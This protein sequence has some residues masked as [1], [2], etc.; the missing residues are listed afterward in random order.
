MDEN[1]SSAKLLDEE[2]IDTLT[3]NEIIRSKIEE[4][5]S[6]AVAVCPLNLLEISKGIRGA[7]SWQGN[8]RGSLLLPDDFFR[9]MEFRMSDWERPVHEAIS[10]DDARYEMQFS[11]YRGIGG[12]PQRPV[13]AITRHPEG[14]TLE[15]FTCR[16]E[17]ATIAHGIYYPTPSID[18]HDGIEIPRRCHRG[19]LYKIASLAA[20]S[21]GNHDMANIF[22]ELSNQLTI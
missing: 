3:L 14:L 15:F 17:S 8:G 9:L 4:G 22:S 21:L 20:S 7:I 10:A 19:A 18:I 6:A 11:R 16:S 1:N 5:V 12:T 2:D 13:V